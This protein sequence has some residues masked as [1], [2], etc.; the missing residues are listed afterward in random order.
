MAAETQV[1]YMTTHCSLFMTQSILPLLPEAAGLSLEVN[2]EALICIFFAQSHILPR[3][4][5]LY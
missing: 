5:L 2:P 4:S 3:A 1:Q